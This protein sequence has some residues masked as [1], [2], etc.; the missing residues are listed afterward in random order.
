M[1][2][3]TIKVSGIVRWIKCA[4]C[5]K[6]GGTLIKT[7]GGRYVHKGRCSDFPQIFKKE[8]DK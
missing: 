7:E 4:I 8:K 1:T 2:S 6:G 3:K 5:G